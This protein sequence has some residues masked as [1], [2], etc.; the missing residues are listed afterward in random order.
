MQSPL[1]DP[2]TLFMIHRPSMICSLL[3][4]PL[5]PYLVPFSPHPLPSSQTCSSWY[6]PFASAVP[7]DRC[8]SPNIHRAIS[9]LLLG[10]YSEFTLL[11]DIYGNTIFNKHPKTIQWGKI[12][13]FNKRWDNWLAPYEKNWSWTLI[14]HMKIKLKWIS[15]LHLTYKL[16]NSLLK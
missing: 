10:L 12:S 14:P 1:Y 4:S 3:P 9:S 2:Q 6:L 13:L 11:S 15:Y 8:S 16:M 7:A 5:W